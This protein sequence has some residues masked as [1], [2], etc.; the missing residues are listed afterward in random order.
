[1]QVFRSHITLSL[2]YRCPVYAQLGQ[3]GNLHFYGV[4]GVPSQTL[5]LYLLL[6]MISAISTVVL[7]MKQNMSRTYAYVAFDASCSAFCKSNGST[8]LSAIVCGTS[9]SNLCLLTD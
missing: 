1:M 3:I 5:V 2:P 4:D 8:H 9:V 7:A 6:I